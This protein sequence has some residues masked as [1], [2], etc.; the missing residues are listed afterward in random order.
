MKQLRRGGHTI[1]DPFLRL[2]ACFRYLAAHLQAWGDLKVGNLKI[3]IAMANLVIHRL[4]AAQHTRALSL[5]EAWLRRS[6]KHTVLAL[7]L[8]KRTMAR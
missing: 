7:S 1:T 8:L 5:E 4:E 2:D 3:Q 6:L